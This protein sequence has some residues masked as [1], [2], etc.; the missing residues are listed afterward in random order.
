[1]KHKNWSP[2]RYPGG[3]ACLAEEIKELLE[4]NNLVGGAYAEP[5]AGGAG[6][7]LNLLFSG[8]VSK[9]YINDLDR[10]IYAFWHTVLNEPEK[11]IE[12]MQNTPITVEE[13]ERQFAVQLDKENA[14]LFDLGFSTFFLNRTNVSGVVR[15]GIIGGKKQTGKYKIDARF[16]KA[17][18]ADKIR[19]ITELK[20]WIHLSNEEASV[21][22]ERMEEE[23]PADSLVFLDP[24]YYVKGASL[25]YNHFSNADHAILANN[26]KK[27]SKHWIVSYDNVKEVRQLY[28]PHR[29]KTYSLNYSVKEH[30]QGSEVMFFS[31]GLI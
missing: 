5:F 10:S 25:Y 17:A 1:M 21:F 12:T 28:T 19:K 3:K 15:G 11:L 30:Y 4:K 29:C 6:L 22:L 18:L 31:K 2:L 26:V 16:N 7:A 8:F 24:P 27:Y 13:H 23:L 9:I 14:S 20:H